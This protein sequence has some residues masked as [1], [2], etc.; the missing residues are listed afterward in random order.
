[1]VTPRRG[2][3]NSQLPVGQANLGANTIRGMEMTDNG[4]GSQAFRPSRRKRLGSWVRAPLSRA[5]V[6]LGITQIIAWGS[7]LYALGVLGR[8]II[9]DTGWSPAIV[10]GGLTVALLAAGSVS[11]PVGN[12]LDRSG[13]RAVMSVGSVIAGAGLVLISV[14]HVPMIYFLGWAVTGIAMRMVLYDAAFVALVQ[15][16]PARGRRSISLLTL[17]GGL[18][19]SL[20][21]PLGAA[22]EHL[23]GWRSTLLAFA[24]LQLLVCLPLH[25]FG[26]RGHESNDVEDSI[27]APVLDQPAAQ[28]FE[29]RPLRGGQRTFAMVLFSFVL[30]VSGTVAGA[31]AAQLVPVLVS[32][33]ID[34]LLA[35]GLASVQG[36][37]QTLSRLVD[38][39]FG[40][41]L[42]PITLG[43]LALGVFPLAF[44]ALLLTSS[45]IAAITFVVLY[46][47][48]N[49]LVTIVRGA[50]PLKLF[51]ATGYGRV[52]GR[53]AV[54]V[55]IM[56]A[57]APLVFALLI[58]RFDI[59]T[60][61][62]L[63]GALTLVSTASMEVL[64]YS[65]RRA[66]A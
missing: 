24:A 57:L 7:T 34:P 41:N 20:M 47:A 45:T 2:S 11:M 6:A 22:L 50:V 3:G 1:M 13:G 32:T 29:D 8:P 28:T 58:E 51:G 39:V 9:A 65:Y 12:R 54:P 55:L 37:A 5:I 61:A 59:R 16:S 62:L 23:Y 56:N 63:L 64:A 35:V 36:V 25:W 49:G 60:G 33:G 42:S 38:L 27:V 52:L 15:L 10:Y 19:S 18:A 17:F 26:L 31:L 53:L 30:A 66:R 14:A 4:V 21:W 48:A 40:R 46:G 43:R 44:A